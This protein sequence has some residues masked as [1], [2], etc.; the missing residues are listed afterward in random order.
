MN[1]KCRAGKEIEAREGRIERVRRYEML[2][3]RALNA[4]RT[5][6]EI[7]TAEEETFAELASYY[8]SGDWLKDYEADEAGELPENLKRG[9]LSQD[10]LFDLLAEHD[11]WQ[12]I[13]IL[14]ASL[15]RTY[16]QPFRTSER[17]KRRPRN[18]RKAS[19]LI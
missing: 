1:D 7:W 15:P 10:G 12:D 14:C 8:E 2:Y 13:S 3:D 11:R 17:T 18:V 4:V 6:T 16:G 9:V 5:I 19:L